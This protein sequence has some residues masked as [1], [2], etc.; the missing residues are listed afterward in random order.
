VAGVINAYTGFAVVSLGWTAQFILVVGE[1]CEFLHLREVG[2]LEPRCCRGI[3]SRPKRT[4]LLQ[5]RRN[6]GQQDRFI[7]CR[8][9]L[10][11]SQSTC[12]AEVDQ[13][14]GVEHDA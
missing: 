13:S 5:F 7:L 1:G 8:R 9:G 14:S 3:E 11:F 12:S 10:R 2:G 4:S 6:M